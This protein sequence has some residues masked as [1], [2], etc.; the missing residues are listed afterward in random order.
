MYEQKID[1]HSCL[2][3]A[4]VA[5][6]SVVRPRSITGSQGTVGRM[7]DKGHEHQCNTEQ[8]APGH[9]KNKY[10]GEFCLTQVRFRALALTHFF[11][12][13]VRLEVI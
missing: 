6:A 4:W 9:Y 8:T 12:W 13:K 3:C 11:F 2:L 7:D 10:Q 5:I 1:E